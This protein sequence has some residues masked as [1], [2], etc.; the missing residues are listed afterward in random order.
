MIENDPL[1]PVALYYIGGKEGTD[2]ELSIGGLSRE[3]QKTLPEH[4]S[5]VLVHTENM[6]PHGS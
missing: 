6:R 5:T 4:L 1:P 3:D 2:A